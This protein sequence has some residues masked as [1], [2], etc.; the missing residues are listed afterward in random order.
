ML[1][2]AAVNV[3]LTEEAEEEEE[4]EA[5]VEEAEE[6]NAEVEDRQGKV[7]N[8]AGVALQNMIKDHGECNSLSAG[9]G[10]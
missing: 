3:D 4:E 8:K 1:S 6:E 5:E 2:T 9:R 7:E 10:E